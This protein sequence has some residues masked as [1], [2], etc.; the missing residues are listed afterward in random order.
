VW[1][2]LAVFVGINF[3]AATSG[4]IFAPDDWYRRLRKPSWQPPDWLFAPAWTILYILIAVAGW[5]VWQ[6][7]EPGA[8][9]LPMALYGIQI[10]LNAAWSWLFFGLKRMRWA[11]WEC[12]AMWVAIAAMI[13]VFVPIDP[14]S[15]L[16]LAP[17]LAWVSF[18]AFLNWTILKLNP[19][20]D[21]SAL[22]GEARRAA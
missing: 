18:A 14:V 10:V 4:G 21:A 6:R 12:L 8:A 2:S 22:Q 7:V 5:R 11:L 1:P 17:Y 9:L 13:A 16:L 19:D 3:A 15:G 20:A